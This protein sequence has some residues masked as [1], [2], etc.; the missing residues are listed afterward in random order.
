MLLLETEA[1]STP[2]LPL[3]LFQNHPNPF[4]PATTI[5][6]YLPEATQVT[7]G[8]YDLAGRLVNRLVDREMKPKGMHQIE[9]KGLDNYGRAVASGVYF[10]RLQ[11]GR[12]T[13]SRKIVLLK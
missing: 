4:N 2:E 13:I 3:T 6:Y 7:L 5:S 10:Y 12:E 9:W 11:T 8:I 1:I